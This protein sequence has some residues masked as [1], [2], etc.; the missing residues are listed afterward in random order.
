MKINRGYIVLG[1]IIAFTLFFELAAHADEFD[2]ATTLT[3]SEAIQIPGQVLPA[4]TYVFQLA[5]SSSD[6]GIVQIFSA[7]RSILYG[8]FLTN[9]TLRQETTDDT[10][11]TLAEPESGGP[12]ALLKWFYPGRET[13]HEFVYSG[14]QEKL[15]AQDTQLTIVANQQ[16]TADSETTGAGN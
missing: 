12:D 2:Q 3:F 6:R 10:A 4:G 1:L 15:L 11:V 8:T 13:G 14:Q 9:A 7:D 16:S 5:D